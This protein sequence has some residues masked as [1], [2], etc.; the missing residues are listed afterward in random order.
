VVSTLGVAAFFLLIEVIERR[1][2]PVAEMLAV[3]AEAF[4]IEEREEREEE[5]GIAIPSTMVLLGL[6]FLG[7][8]LL[9]ASLPPL[10][11]FVAK[12]ALFAALVEPVPVPVSAWVLIALLTLS[13]FVSLIALSRFG[14]RV[15]W[16]AGEDALARVRVLEF[17]PI[18]LLLLLCAALTVAAAPVMR[19]MHATAEA[20]H[21]PASY[22][23]AVL[24][25]P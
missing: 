1:R 22:V 3:T 24:A 6:A 19:Y 9:L 16:G 7:C 12:F 2:H 21:A 20:L 25:S 17:A 5:I 10:P 14:I 18:V 13:G 8:A 4:G 11:G 23:R 15:F